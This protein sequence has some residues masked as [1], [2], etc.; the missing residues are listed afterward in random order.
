MSALPGAGP[1]PRSSSRADM[2]DTRRALFLDIDGVLNH[3][4]FT[5]ARKERPPYEPHERLD[6]ACVRRLGAL[7]SAAAAGRGEP[8]LVLTSN[9]RLKHGRDVTQA[10][11]RY[12]EPD[13]TIDA[14]TPDLGLRDDEDAWAGGLREADCHRALALLHGSNDP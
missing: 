14:E 12:H 5:L 8:L 7:L 2:K 3:A 4:A 13:L 11:L 10:A 1:A 6:G 9:W